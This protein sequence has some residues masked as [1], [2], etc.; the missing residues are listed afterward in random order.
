MNSQNNKEEPKLF[1]FT[2]PGKPQGKARARTFYDSRSGKM[3]SVTPE[4]TV[5]YGK[6]DQDLFPTEIRTE[7]VFG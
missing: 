5:L 7:T 2:V 4:K 6:P 3:S 1:T